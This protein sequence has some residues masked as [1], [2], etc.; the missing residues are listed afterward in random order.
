MAQAGAAA[1][2]LIDSDQIAGTPVYSADAGR[3]GTIRRVI[4]LQY[5]P[6]SISRT[7]QAKSVGGDTA[8]RSEALLKFS[9]ELGRRTE[10]K[11]DSSHFFRL[12]E[13]IS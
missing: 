13:S 2:P 9:V 8:D 11:I 7:L 12:L 4:T 6:D 10:G 5:N 3:I 1:R